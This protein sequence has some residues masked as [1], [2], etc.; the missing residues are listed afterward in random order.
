MKIKTK[1]YILV[2]YITEFF[3]QKDILRE[4]HFKTFLEISNREYDKQFIQPEI[5]KKNKK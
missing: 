4:S 2:N 5:K 1:E 3:T